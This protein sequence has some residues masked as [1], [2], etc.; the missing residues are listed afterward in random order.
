M[1]GT[2]LEEKLRKSTP[3][4]YQFY[5]GKSNVI[6]SPFEAPGKRNQNYTSYSFVSNAIFYDH[7]SNL[8]LKPG[9]MY[10]TTNK[11][12][13]SKSME[14]LPGNLE[15]QNLARGQKTRSNIRTNMTTMENDFGGR[16]NDIYKQKLGMKQGFSKDNRSQ[17]KHISTPSSNPIVNQD[18]AP[19]P[20]RSRN[21][22]LER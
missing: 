9:E 2:L 5:D 13:Q 22:G 20:K 10:I 6:G 3:Q 7:Q 17:K 12:A 11:L 16:L 15:E 18:L 21:K 8:G 1:P 19:Q 4:K 14:R